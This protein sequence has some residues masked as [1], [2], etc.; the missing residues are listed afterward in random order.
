M[1]TARV[2]PVMLRGVS[3]RELCARRYPGHPRGC[4]NRGRA[5]CPPGARPLGE[6]LDLRL[7]TFVVWNAFPLGRHVTRMRWK[8]P[9]WTVRQ[10]VCCLYWQ[11]TARKQLRAEIAKFMAKYVGDWTVLTCPEA[12]GVDVTA[13]MR[14]AGVELEWPPT[15][16]AY[17]V[18]LAGRPG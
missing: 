15:V 3:A 11:G 2:R 14:A 18:A 16:T 12:H 10:L 8:H 13:T 5:G 9:G 4:P 1:P 6:V 17:Q 7:P